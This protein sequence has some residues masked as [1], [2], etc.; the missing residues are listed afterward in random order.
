MGAT[1]LTVAAFLVMEPVTYLL[2]RFVMHGPGVVW[3]RSHHARRAGLLERNDLYPVVFASTTIAVMA[4]G[5]FVEPV[6]VLLWIGLGV[7]LYGMAYLFVHDGYIHRRLPGLT[8]RVG[9]LERLAEAHALH[10]RF[11][12]EPYGMLFPIVPSEL[13]RRSQRTDRPEAADLGARA[14]SP[15]PLSVGTESG[16]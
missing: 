7:T 8:A 4:L 13:R 3:H 16:G 12:A 6:H 2:H 10:H 15:S 11:G 1:L 14:P 9:P 5:A